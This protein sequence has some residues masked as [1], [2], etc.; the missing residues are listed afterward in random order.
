MDA[1]ERA[2]RRE[3]RRLAAKATELMTAALEDRLLFVPEREWNPAVEQLEV[4]RVRVVV[5]PREPS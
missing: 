3:M 2:Y 5:L 4:V 1:D